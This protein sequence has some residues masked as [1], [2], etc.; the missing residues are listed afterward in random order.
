MIALSPNT[1]IYLATDAIDFRCGIDGV[2]SRCRTI[3]EQDPMCGG[4]F[5]FRNRNKTSIKILNYDGQGFWLHQK[6][7]SS[8]RF[9]W[10]PSS[11]DR[12]LIISVAQLNVLLW[13]GDPQR[14]NLAQDW[15]PLDHAASLTKF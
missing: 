11:G 3:I 15:K 2:A 7:L 5:I 10:W 8:H 14:A 1:R 4:L 13:N 9:K 12:S 6:R